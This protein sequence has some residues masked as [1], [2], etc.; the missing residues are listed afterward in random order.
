MQSSNKLKYRRFS[1]GEIKL[2]TNG[3]SDQYFLGEDEL[4]KIYRGNIRENDHDYVV[5]VKRVDNEYKIMLQNEIDSL[6][7]FHHSNIIYLLGYCEVD[8][9]IL[10]YD[11]MPNGSLYYYLFNNKNQRCN[12]T[13]EQRLEICIGTAN[14]LNHLHFGTKSSIIVHGDVNSSNI[15]LDGNFA[16]K[17]LAPQFECCLQYYI[18]TIKGL[19]DD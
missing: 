10:L 12:L 18:T 9:K 7:S 19:I 16:A 3:F 2:A 15:F 11:F 14:G 17:L 6:S 8:E 4:G 5:I 1:I 13:V